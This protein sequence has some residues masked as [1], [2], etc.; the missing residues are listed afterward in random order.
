METGNVLLWGFAATLILTLFMACSKPLGFTR[1]DIP[2]MLGTMFTGNRNYAPLIGFFVHLFIGWIFAFLYDLTFI[3]AGIS[4]WWFGLIIGFI[5]A[6]FVLSVGLQ[7]I[8]YLHPRMATHLQGP[9][10]GRL[11]QPPGFF[12]LNY[13]YGTPVCTFLAHM[14][15]GSILGYFL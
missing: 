15:Y 6:A 14:I 8:N 10:P 2:F 12:A 1:M 9:T 4:T 7:V 3:S 5:H 13:G 11:L